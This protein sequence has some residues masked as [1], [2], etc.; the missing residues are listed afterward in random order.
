MSAP[1]PITVAVV[2]D[3]P[4]LVSAF[5]ALLNAQPDIEVVGTAAD[6][7]SAVRLAERAAPDVMLMDIRMP[8]IDGVEATRRIADRGD[9]PRVLI[10]TTFNVD[11]LVLGAVRAGARGFL[12]KDADPE[13]VIAAIRAVHRG[14]AVIAGAAAPHLLQ[15]YREGH[16]VTAAPMPGR[17]TTR[18]TEV[19]TLV[20]RGLT[21]HEIAAELVVAETT[22]KTHVGNLLTKLGCRDR[23]ALVV[24]AY[25]CGLVVPDGLLPPRG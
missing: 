20:A 4:L 21:N 22:V 6:G 19:L 23:V 2:D 13:E 15:A 14:E 24:L 16:T 11:E 5:V 12:L 7:G 18:E 9:R 25:S 1:P 10:L 8:G 17:L 3:Q